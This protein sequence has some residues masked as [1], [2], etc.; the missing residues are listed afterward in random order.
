MSITLTKITPTQHTS[1]VKWIT[2]VLHGED[3][4]DTTP[5]ECYRVID[6][7]YDGGWPQFILDLGVEGLL[8]EGQR[9][10]HEGYGMGVC[11]ESESNGHVP[12][13]FDNQLTPDPIVMKTWAVMTLLDV[14]TV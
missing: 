1:A 14:T 10:I 12:V 3:W 7:W 13:L 4:T 9:V 5:Q 2:V 6:T 11:T 8:T